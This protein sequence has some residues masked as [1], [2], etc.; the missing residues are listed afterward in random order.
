[1]TRILIPRSDNVSAKIIEA[2]D[3][4]KYWGTIISDYV[5]CGFSLSAGSGLAV[6]VSAGT[7]RLKGL[8]V[9]NSTTCT[10]SSLTACATNYIYATI[11]RD[12]TCEP[13]AWS[14]SQNTTGTA[15]TDSM[16]LGSA[17]T[18]ATS[19][20]AVDNLLKNES[21]GLDGGDLVFGAG[22]DGTVTISTNT[23][24]T[25]NKYYQNLTIDAGVTLTGTTSPLVVSV[26]G[27]LTVNGTL[28]MSCKGGSGG[29][30][31]GGTGG[32]A[33]NLVQ[34]PG[35]AG[36][37]NVGTGGAAGAPN[38]GGGG[39][40]TGNGAGGGGGGGG[41]FGPSRNGGAGQGGSSANTAG[42][43][44]GS[45]GSAFTDYES[46]LIFLSSPSNVVGA[47][48][49]GGAN[50]A[51]GGSG[52]GSWSGSNPGGSGSGGQGGSGGGGGGTLV[53]AA[54]KIIVGSCGVISSDGG[55]G[56][57]GTS[58][59][60]GNPGGTCKAGGGGGGGGGGGSGG[61]GGNGGLLFLAYAKL[62]NNGTI[63]V[64]AGTGGSGGGGGS[65]G[66]GGTGNNG[67]PGGAGGPGTAGGSGGVSGNAGIIRQF[68]V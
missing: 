8:Y 22:S 51:G 49:G 61:G 19:V 46:V 3:W 23:C 66:S 42:G 38:N 24:L 25:Q 68:K 32:N 21:S 28:T 6:D 2:S 4:E 63:S 27:T 55:I 52:G 34:P 15:P 26:A 60:P 18:D 57:T 35:G 50:G 39:T 31:G 13:Q 67:Q 14:F 36:A 5:V 20:T 56:G 45:T 40:A 48:G 29:A 54:R 59:N 43:A 17:T 12:P 47:G 33:I 30:V 37:S 64:V 10:V 41:K 1:M 9:N 16:V 58:G 65:G 44:G 62:T 11:C 7:L 53:V